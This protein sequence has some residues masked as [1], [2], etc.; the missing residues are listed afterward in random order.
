MIKPKLYFFFYFTAGK[1]QFVAG[2]TDE[3]LWSC[4]YFN[5][6]SAKGLFHIVFYHNC[7][8][9]EVNFDCLLKQKFVIK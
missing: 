9:F 3:Q 8:E 7:V 4:G 5:S 6:E 2:L 1:N